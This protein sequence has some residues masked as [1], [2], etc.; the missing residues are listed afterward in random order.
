VETITQL[1][2]GWEASI[3]IRDDLK[4]KIDSLIVYTA[5]LQEKNDGLWNSLWISRGKLS[6]CK[7]LQ[8]LGFGLKELKQLSG[9]IKEV[10]D[11]N[12]IPPNMAV[13]KFFEEIEKNYDIMLGFDSKLKGLKSEI[14]K[15]NDELIIVQKNLVHKEQ[16]VKALGELI[17]MGLDDKKILN[18][19]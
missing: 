18:L 4:K 15:T 8:D 3:A 12:N 10:A 19:A 2:S 17:L 11:A 13:W 6:L 16:V 1:L 9:T 14:V 7:D 5:E